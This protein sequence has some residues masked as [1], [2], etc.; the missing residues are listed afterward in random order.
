MDA[1][2]EKA[3]RDIDD[4][5]CHVIHVLEDP[6]HP[7]FSYSIGIQ[8][9]TGAPEL[10][11][12]GMKQPVAHFM[13]NEYNSRVLA[14]EAF[15]PGQRASG[16]IEG[17]DIE[18]RLVHPSHYRGYLAWALWLYKGAEFKVLQAVFPTT[19]GTWPWEAETSEWFRY[20]QPMLDKP[21]P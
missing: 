16:F 15:A 10:I 13:I 14:R 12:A 7:P 1:G 19:K 17:F 18:F 11:V 4:Y 9:K 20:N 5:G 6:E 21:A 8:L 2:E 3:L